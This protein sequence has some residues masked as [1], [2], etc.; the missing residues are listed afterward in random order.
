[1][2]VIQLRL[3]LV[4]AAVTGTAVGDNL[5]ECERGSDAGS[6]GLSVAATSTDTGL[7]SRRGVDVHSSNCFSFL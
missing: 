6:R 2:A 3:G 4:P 7:W 5:H 1:M